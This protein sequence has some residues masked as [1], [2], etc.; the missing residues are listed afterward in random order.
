MPLV[1]AHRGASAVEHEN[2]LAAFRRAVAMGADGIELD[3]H[4]TAD[5]VIVV[6]HDP[7]LNGH[8]IRSTSWDALRDATLPNGEPIPTLAQALRAIGGGRSVFV[9]IKHLEPRHD[10]ALLS[11]LDRAPH[12]L[13]CHVHSFDHRIVKRLRERRPDLVTGV[14]S[15][16]Y[17]VTP[18]AQLRDAG[19]SALWQERS[20]VDRALVD[21]V[22]AA[23]A[24]VYVWTVDHADEARRFAAWGV[25]AI[26]TNRPDQIREALT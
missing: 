9:E 6:Y 26:C 3:V 10:A 22:H 25:D 13:R 12:G 21:Q 4:A 14:L 16:S 19:A 1:I 2:S 7:E 18:V 11:V 17:P 15:M 24:R 20:L 5:G 8:A 23:R